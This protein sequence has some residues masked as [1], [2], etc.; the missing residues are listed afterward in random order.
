MDTTHRQVNTN[1][2]RTYIAQAGHGPLVVMLHNSPEVW[3]ARR[4]VQAGGELAIMQDNI[5]ATRNHHT[6]SPEPACHPAPGLAT[7]IARS[8]C[9]TRHW[10]QASF[11]NNL[12]ETYPDWIPV[13]TRLTVKPDKVV[14]VMTHLHGFRCCRQRRQPCGY[15]GRVRLRPGT[16]CVLHQ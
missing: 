14:R 7:H 2:I 10:V 9:S 5:V 6:P 15:P 11:T 12:P 4:A 1:G 3:Y 16:E 13:D 8:R